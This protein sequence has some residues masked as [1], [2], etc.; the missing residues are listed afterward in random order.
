MSRIATLVLLFVFCAIATAQSSPPP[1]LLAV[2]SAFV[3]G[4]YE[5]VELMTLRLLQGDAELT[6]DETARLN[7]TAGYALIMLGRESEA[8]SYFNHAL[9]AVPDLTLD[10]VQVSPKF[11][12]VFDEVKAARPAVVD[13][14]DQAAASDQS[15]QQNTFDQKPRQS[16]HVAPQSQ[17]MNLILPGSGQW[18][19]GHPVRGALLFGLQATALGVL[20]WQLNELEDSRGD[21]LAETDPARISAAYNNYND[22][23]QAAWG[24]GIAAGLVY[25][26]AQAD[27]AFLTPAQARTSALQVVPTPSGMGLC[28]RW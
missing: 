13:N 6:P 5:Q 18:R 11:R 24:A 16:M 8:R 3:E 4:R 23:Y 12:V 9:D 10:P 26:A 20:I 17:V 15:V 2:D 25:L 22:N 27:L 28:L 7:L 14:A 19:E 21:Y 1:D